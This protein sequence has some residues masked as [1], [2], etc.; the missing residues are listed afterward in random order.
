VIG[1]NNRDLA[2]LDV[3]PRRTFELLPL[4][5]PGRVVVSESGLHRREQLD[6]LAREGVDAVLV[7]EALMRSTDIEATCRALTAPEEGLDAAAR[8]SPGAGGFR[9]G[10]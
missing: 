2:T 3:D 6:E 5:P 1:I 9:M 10:S 4:V 7:G 8:P